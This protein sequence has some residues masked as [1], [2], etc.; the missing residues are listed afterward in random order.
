MVIPKRDRWCQDSLALTLSLVI[1]T[2]T[3]PKWVLSLSWLHTQACTHTH[4]HTHTHTLFKMCG[5]KHLTREKA[6]I[7]KK[8]FVRFQK[9]DVV[10]QKLYDST[11]E[12]QKVTRNSG[13]K[14][15]AVFRRIEDPLTSMDPCWERERE[16]E[17]ERA[18]C[19]DNLCM[20][21]ICVCIHVVCCGVYVCVC[22]CVHA[23]MLVHECM[24]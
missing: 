11:E 13:E 23:C 16:R 4:T 19:L 21:L 2:S 17:R 1:P 7:Q 20:W 22:M 15:L 8:L 9:E 14:W 10:V 24:W 18:Y 6:E 5:K 12:G 3:S